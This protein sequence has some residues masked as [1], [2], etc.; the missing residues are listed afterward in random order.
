MTHRRRDAVGRRAAVILLVVGALVA[1]APLLWAWASQHQLP[2]NLN[3]GAVTRLAE[4]ATTT[5]P[6]VDAPTTGPTPSAPSQRSGSS[7]APDSSEAPE[8]SSPDVPEWATSVSIQAGAARAAA[9]AAAPSR[10]RIPDLGADVPIIA[11]GVDE[12][13]QMAIP[14]NVSQVGW[15]RYGPAPGSAAGSVVMSGHVD[16][17]TEGR[18]V[19]AGLAQIDIDDPI[20]VTDEN[21]T[22]RTYRVI[23]RESYD[24]ATAPMSELF[25][26]SGPPRLTLITCGGEFDAT[27]RSYSHNVVVTAEPVEQHPAAP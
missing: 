15:Y 14:E 17:A 13:G 4:S 16:S 9:P 24:K 6:A 21:G 25:S 5:S 18:G 19:L 22:E 26:R 27:V 11:V 12:T 1:V 7:K 8:P 23:S 10:L 2:E 20:I 3:P